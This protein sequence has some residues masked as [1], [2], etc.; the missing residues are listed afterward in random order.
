MDFK[1]EYK[2]KNLLIIFQ[3]A[4]DGNLCGKAKF[5]FE[6]YTT[7]YS[8]LYIKDTYFDWYQKI[9]VEVKDK[10]VEI[11]NRYKFD[12]VI[13]LGISMGGYA[14]ILFNSLFSF[15]L[16]IAINPQINLT[17]SF[18]EN[19]TGTIDCICF[20]DMNKKYSEKYL[21][22]NNI[23]NNDTKIILMTSMNNKWDSYQIKSIKEKCI[24]K[25]YPTKDHCFFQGNVK[26]FY[27]DITDLIDKYILINSSYTTILNRKI[28]FSGFRAYFEKDISTVNE[29]LLQSVENINNNKVLI[30]YTFNYNKNSGGIS[31]AH[32]LV[33]KLN[34]IYERTVAYVC[35]VLGNFFPIH[36]KDKF[37]WFEG[38][39]GNMFLENNKNLNSIKQ[40]DLNDILLN[41]EWNTP[42]VP[43]DI[44][45][46]RNNIVIYSENVYGNPIEQKHVVRW[47]LYFDINNSIDLDDIIVYYSFDYLIK[48]NQKL[49]TKNITLDFPLHIVHNYEY[50]LK[51]YVDKKLTRKDGYCYTIRKGNFDCKL[52]PKNIEKGIELTYE[53]NEDE[54]IQYFNTYKYFICYDKH[55]FLLV[56]AE[57]CGCISI[58]VSSESPSEIWPVSPWMNFNIKTINEINTTSRGNIRKYL[59]LKNRYQETEIK[60][61]FEYTNCFT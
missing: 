14:S 11:L 9:I 35:P 48:S 4:N 21:D 29:V 47:I 52:L 34:T 5:D 45:L 16:A 24:I 44:L 54:I 22:L 46:N 10:I 55:T 36:K 31:N 25:S 2:N 43:V 6:N 38:V 7:N 56:L 30:V 3:S 59:M 42:I 23:L 12:L 1:F 50:I 53:M 33:H 28:D 17:D 26:L 27:K 37:V 60:K 58:V 49:F 18:K 61:F 51:K 57:L 41:P 13:T 8:K 15:D 20:H 19:F 39:T 32:Y 40:S